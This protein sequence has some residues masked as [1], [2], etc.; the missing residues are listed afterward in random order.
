MKTMEKP[1]Y[2]A[3]A[4]LYFPQGSKTNYNLW[5]YQDQQ[6]AK[7]HADNIGA[8]VIEISKGQIWRVSKPI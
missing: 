7:I 6:S 5:Y 4:M 3:Q 1:F 8:R 2:E